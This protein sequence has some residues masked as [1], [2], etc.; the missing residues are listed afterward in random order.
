MNYYILPKKNDK[1]SINIKTTSVEDL[2]PYVS[3]SVYHYLNIV[4]KQIDEIQKKDNIIDYDLIYKIS[5]PYEFIFSNVPGLKYSV[6]K[7]KPLNNIFYIFMEILIN[8]NILDFFNNSEIKTFFYGKNISS[9][10][11]CMNMLR[12]DYNDIYKFH[13]EIQEITNDDFNSSEKKSFDFM[14]FELKN[15]VNEDQTNEYIIT[16]IRCLQRILIYQKKNG[17][18]VIKL[19]NLF[20]KPLIDILYILTNLYEKI[21]IVKMNTTNIVNGERIIIC[22]N[23]IQNDE[24]W[25]ENDSIK[26]LALANDL[27]LQ[28]ENVNNSSQMIE[29]IIDNKL[30]YYFINKIEDSNVNIGHSQ[31]E[32]LDLILYM[33]KNK[34][35]DEKIETIKKNNI[36]KCIQWCEK[37][38]IP[39]NKCIDKINIFLPCANYIAETIE[40]ID[41]K[42]HHET[43]YDDVEDEIISKILKN[44]NDTINDDD[45][46]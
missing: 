9:T 27:Q 43:E 30:P 36:I 28:L 25:I 2:Q 23:F 12:E 33:I 13:G 19:N 31:I 35:R 37:Y 29:S 38:K 32:Q 7:L 4:L 22:K 15:Y 26:Y 8:F 39:Y 44:N 20:Y 17:I 41:N 10:I 5:N 24:Y 34:N 18:C 14:F 45:H 16:M 3:S 6:S 40:D 11:E 21:Y 42:T 46:I 1:I